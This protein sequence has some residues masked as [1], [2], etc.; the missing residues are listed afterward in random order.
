MKVNSQMENCERG[1]VDWFDEKKGFG[2][3]SP[4]SGGEDVFVHFT[5]IEQESGYRKLKA[6]EQVSFVRVMK[7]TK[8]Q[9]TKVKRGINEILPQGADHSFQGRDSLPQANPFSR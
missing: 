5:E 6:G 8:P 7:A 1:K 2:F 4:E 9:A 3:I